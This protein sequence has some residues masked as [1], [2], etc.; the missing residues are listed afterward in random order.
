MGYDGC[1]HGGG[2]GWGYG[3]LNGGVGWKLGVF[4]R[5]GSWNGQGLVIESDIDEYMN[6]Y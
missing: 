5:R 1:G 2:T 3:V 4:E 6:N